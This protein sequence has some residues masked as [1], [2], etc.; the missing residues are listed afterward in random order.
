[1]YR[2]YEK[3]TRHKAFFDTYELYAK[4]RR[5]MLPGY[6]DTAIETLSD[7]S[8][9]VTWTTMEILYG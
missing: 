8:I 1:M 6:T 2:R 3:V 4:W 7:K 9:V 5:A